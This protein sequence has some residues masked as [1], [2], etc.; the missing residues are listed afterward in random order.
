MK[1]YIELVTPFETPAG[2]DAARVAVLEALLSMCPSQG[3]VEQ[4]A[5][6][7]GIPVPPA[8]THD[9]LRGDE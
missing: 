5:A 6:A 4:L 8:S 3:R 7:W 1:T 9:V 2:R